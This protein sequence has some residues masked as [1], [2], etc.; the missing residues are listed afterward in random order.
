MT[1]GSE[2]MQSADDSRPVALITGASLG[3]GRAVA[4]ELAQDGFRLVITARRPALLEDAAAEVRALTDVVALP[5][6]VADRAHA[7]EL[8]RRAMERFGRVDVLVNNA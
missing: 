4:K 1:A 7:Q 8:V 6:D 3:L 2:H 5:G